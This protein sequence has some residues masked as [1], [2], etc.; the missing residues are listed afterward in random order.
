MLYHFFRQCRMTMNWKFCLE[1]LAIANLNQKKKQKQT[2]GSDFIKCITCWKNEKNPRSCKGYT[3]I[4]SL[5]VTTP[6]NDS[7][8]ISNISDEQTITNKNSCRSSWSSIPVL[9]IFWFQKF[10][11]CVIVSINCRKREQFKIKHQIL[12]MRN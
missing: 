11:V 1:F 10:R 4:V 2:G 12:R 5:T 3:T 6:A 8:G 9:I 7:S